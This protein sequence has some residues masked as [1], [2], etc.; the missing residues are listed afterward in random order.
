[1]VPVQVP[2]TT[3]NPANRDPLTDVCIVIKRLGP[4]VIT[5][6]LQIDATLMN[7][8]V[9]L[10]MICPILTFGLEVGLNL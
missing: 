8:Y 7:K 6:T 9:R 5:A 3:D 4:G 2:I 10:I 1:M